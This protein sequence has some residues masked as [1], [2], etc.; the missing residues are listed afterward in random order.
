MSRRERKRMRTEAVQRAEA[1]DERDVAEA[2]GP[3]HSYGLRD[4][5]GGLWVV[6]R[7]DGDREEVVSRPNRKALA[8]HTMLERVEQDEWR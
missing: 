2:Q 6:V 7:V 5:G 1:G 8:L 4:Q 3:S